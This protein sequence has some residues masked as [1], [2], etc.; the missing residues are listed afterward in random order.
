MNK[1]IKRI[2]N[3]DI[4]SIEHN[5][6]NEAGI[7]IEFDEQ[8]M[9]SARAMI[10]GPKDSIY[11]GGF[12]FF[13]INFPKNYPYSPPDVAYVPVNNIRIHPNLYVG[14]HKSGYGKVCL[15]IL[16]TWNGPQWTTIM[17]ISTVLLSIQSILDKYPLLNEPGYTLSEKRHHK[18]IYDFNDVAF[19]ETISSLIIKNYDRTPSD[20]SI[21]KDIM[22]DYIK[23]NFTEINNN[24]NK[25]LDI[26][27]R[28]IIQELYRLNY[29]IDNNELLKEYL[30]FCSRNNLKIEQ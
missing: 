14:H 16:G 9:L 12:L 10:I 2:V 25:R 19:S 1:A 26:K 28:K 17:D 30:A 22:N 8:N 6:L 23:T 11:E 21:F 20:F 18:I 7:F 3:K 4:K 24:I 13:Y 27:N 5:K 29:S 15:S